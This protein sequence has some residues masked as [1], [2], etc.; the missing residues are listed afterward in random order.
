MKD[1]SCHRMALLAFC[2]SLGNS[3]NSKGNVREDSSIL[4]VARQIDFEKDENA[5]SAIAKG[6]MNS[7]RKEFSKNDGEFS[8]TCSSLSLDESVP[9][10]DPN[11]P[12]SPQPLT[13]NSHKD[14]KL[15]SETIAS[16]IFKTFTKSIEWRK[17]C[18]TES[19]SQSLW[20]A[21][22]KMK[23]SGASDGDLKSLLKTPPAVVIS[24]LKESRIKV[25]AARTFFRVLP[26]LWDKNDD[27]QKTND[28]QSYL[29]YVLTFKTVLNISSPSGY[30]EVTLEAPGTIQ[31]SFARTKS[32]E[33][34]LRSVAIVIDTR[35]LATIIEK[36]NRIIV[37]AAVESLLPSMKTGR[38]EVELFPEECE[39]PKLRNGPPMSQSPTYDR[40]MKIST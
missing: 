3:F 40:K 26:T 29:T 34:D 13:G 38:T 20:A 39:T 23:Q 5:M 4:S 30:S 10:Q 22:R 19:L 18:W 9:K 1:I 25:L 24:C 8:F 14:L 2:A 17:R 7:K 11:S 27:R 28:D 32:S 16:N 12:F 21:E 31:G 36:S 33:S 6:L 37:R 35:V 15:A